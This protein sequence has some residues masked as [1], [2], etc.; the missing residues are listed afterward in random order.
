GCSFQTDVRAKLARPDIGTASGASATGR[1]S[2]RLRGPPA[3]RLSSSVAHFR[4]TCEQSSPAPISAP[5]AVPR[6]RAAHHHAFQHGLTADGCHVVVALA[7]AGAAGLLEPA[8]EPLHAAARVDQLL[9]TGVERVAVRADLDME[10]GLRGTRLERV[11]A[12]ARHGCEDVFGVNIRLHS[13]S[14]SRI[15]AAVLGATL[16]PE[17][18]AATVWPGSRSTFPLVSAAAVAAPASSQASFIRP[19]MKRNASFSAAS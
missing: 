10:L 18:T 2:S 13:C 12:G 9:L 17:T 19:Y 15:A 6:R 4:R 7:A 5:Q 3:L 8:L 16:P 11:P 14:E 1:A